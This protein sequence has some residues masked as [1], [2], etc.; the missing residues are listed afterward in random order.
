MILLVDG[1]EHEGI[2]LVNA[3]LFGLNEP[4]LEL[5]DG[6]CQQMSFVE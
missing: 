6:V 3:G 5:L 4:L 2:G 1:A